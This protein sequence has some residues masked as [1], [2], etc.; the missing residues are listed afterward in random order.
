MAEFGFKLRHL[1]FTVCATNY[2]TMMYLRITALYLFVGWIY[3]GWIHRK[4]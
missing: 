1:D 2:L 4:T 3:V